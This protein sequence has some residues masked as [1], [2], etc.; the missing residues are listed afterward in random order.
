MFYAKYLTTRFEFKFKKLKY[1]KNK[2]QQLKLLGDLVSPGLLGVL[3]WGHPS[4]DHSPDYSLILKQPKKNVHTF[5]KLEM[6][7]IQTA[8]V[9]SWEKAKCG[10]YWGFLAGCWKALTQCT[11]QSYLHAM[12]KLFL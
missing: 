3:V 11:K 9:F 10:F 6:Y 12:L 8:G 4:L 1:T 7:F 5:G 2:K